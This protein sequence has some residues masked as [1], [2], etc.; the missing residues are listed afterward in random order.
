MSVYLQAGGFARR[1]KDPMV[2]SRPWGYELY[3]TH[4]YPDGARRE[5]FATLRDA[6]AALRR[7]WA[8][9]S[10]TP[11]PTGEESR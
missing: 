3:P 4:R 11:S 2:R 6:A 10:A 8:E 9:I 1:T 7:E 5:G